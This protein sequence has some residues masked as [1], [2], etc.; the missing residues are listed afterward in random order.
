VGLFLH[1]PLR[2][3]D[4]GD[5]QDPLHGQ[6]PSVVRGREA[7]L[8]RKPLEVRTGVNVVDILPSSPV[9]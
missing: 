4:G 8:R 5:R 3:S 9:L 2:Q 7:E 6:D 1:H